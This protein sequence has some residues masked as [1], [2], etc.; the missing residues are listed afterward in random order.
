M[1]VF[2]SSLYLQH[3]SE[4]KDRWVVNYSLVILIS[5]YQDLWNFGGLTIG[6]SRGV[7][8]I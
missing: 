6:S 3:M 7:G 2:C 1:T 5:L 8:H 4:W